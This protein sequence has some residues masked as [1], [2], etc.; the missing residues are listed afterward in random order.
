MSM[1]DHLAWTTDKPKAPGYYLVRGYAYSE[2][3]RFVEMAAVEVGFDHGELCVNLHETNSDAN[4]LRD[5]YPVD[6]LDET[7]EWCPLH[8]QVKPTTAKGERDGCE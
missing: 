3:D 6:V 1:N 5:G 8:P 2:Y 7:L 4:G